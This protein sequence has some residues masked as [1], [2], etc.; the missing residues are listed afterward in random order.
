MNVKKRIVPIFVA[1]LMVFTMMP[2]MAGSVYADDI[3][4]S[5]EGFSYTLHDN[6]YLVFNGVEDENAEGIN[7][8]TGELTIH[9]FYY[10]SVVR[11][12][13]K[14]AFADNL[15]SGINTVIIPVTVIEIEEMAF[16]QCYGLKSISFPQSVATIGP[17]AFQDCLFLETVSFEDEGDPCYIDSDAFSGCRNLKEVTIP[18]RVYRIDSGAFD[19]CNSLTAVHYGGTRQQ[20]EAIQGDGKPSIDLVEFNYPISQEIKTKGTSIKDLKSAKKAIAV[21]WKKQAAKVNGSHITGYQIRL[22][23]DKKFTKNKKTVT[24]KGYKN[25][26]KKIKNLK[27]K[28]RYYV[29]IRTYKSVGGDKCYS[30][31]S[32]ARSIKTR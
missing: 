27:S 14:N 20:W 10:G 23:T 24:V 2:M 16:F 11:K 29:K 17:Y 25:V 19:Y 32:K 4:Y 8:T 22:A 26:S 1:A 15:P 6:H 3:N 28:K 30:P 7:R 5:I 9:T 18:T 13:G 21:K 31:W 12:I